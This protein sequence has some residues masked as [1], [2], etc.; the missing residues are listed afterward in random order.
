MPELATRLANSSA[1]LN[2][3]SRA[4]TESTLLFAPTTSSR[5][6]GLLHGKCWQILILGRERS[7][8]CGCSRPYTYSPR[9][10]TILAAA[11]FSRMRDYKPT[12]VLASA[13]LLCQLTCKAIWKRMH[14]S[15]FVIPLSIIL[16]VDYVPLARSLCTKNE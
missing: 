14:A 7:R 8:A 5:N 15:R 4:G 11:N 13:Y 6:Y 10:F 12:I 16:S 1:G 2:R 3:P 9:D